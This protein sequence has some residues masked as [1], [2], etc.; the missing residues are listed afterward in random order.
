MKKLLLNL[1]APYVKGM[2][3]DA[4][5]VSEARTHEVVENS[6]RET[7]SNLDRLGDDIRDLRRDLHNATEQINGIDKPEID[8]SLVAV[9]YDE[10]ARVLDYDDV[11]GAIN[12]TTLAEELDAA[13]IA[14]EIDED[15][16]KEL[17]AK[18]RALWPDEQD[19]R[20]DS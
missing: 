17:A 10:L 8:Y 4:L 7:Q 12:L 6:K 9:D 19:E 11:A 15:E 13:D 2:I 18:L 16:L 14:A 5:S 3:A 20:K 1:I